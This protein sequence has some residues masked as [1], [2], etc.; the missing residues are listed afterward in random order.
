MS[1]TWI[2]CVLVAACGGSNGGANG[3]DDTPPDAPGTLSDDGPCDPN[4]MRCN[5]DVVEQ[6]AADGSH[7]VPQN[8]CATFCADGSCALDGLDVATDQSLDGIV[9]VKGAVMVHAGATL[10]TPMGDLTIFADSISVESGGAITSATTGSVMALNGTDSSSNTTVPGGRNASSPLTSDFDSNVSPGGSGGIVVPAQE[11]RAMGG[12]RI[13]LFAPTINMAGQ[14]LANGASGTASPTG[15]CYVPGSGGAGGGVLLVADD[16]TMSGL[17][18]TAGGAGGTPIPACTGTTSNGASGDLGRIKLLYGSKHDITGTTTS[19]RLTQGI[20]PPIPVTSTTHPSPDA[21]YNDGFLSLDINWAKSFPTTMGYYVL[22]DSTPIHPPT[23]ANGTFQSVDQVSFSAND[24]SNGDNYVHIVTIDSM[25][26]IG[27]IESNYHVKINT[28][29]PVMSS[30][31]HPSQTTFVNNTNP[32]FAW[33]YPQTDANVSAVYY[34]LDHFGDTVPALTSTALPATQKQLLQSGLDAGIWVLHVI[35]ADK[36]GRLTK[37]AGNYRVS[38]G[39]DPGIGNLTGTVTDA[40]SA[41][42]SGATV[43]LNHGLFDLGGGTV[44]TVT[45]NSAGSFTLSNI[46]AGT[47]EVEV[48]LATRSAAK[49]V[50]IAP[51]GGTGTVS[52]TLP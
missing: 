30:Q 33:S 46:P 20:A 52:V 21:I 4:A 28:L 44:G 18:S 24:V 36:Q 25:S 16:L 47:W 34:V 31:S 2:I 51:G 14:I 11:V 13:R 27:T 10:T 50:S 3:G 49:N 39:A 22:L 43:T 42:V 19:G 48:T 12:G 40:A 15:S 41:P 5:G 38:I 32:F 45:T 1:R 7:W 26:Q 23:A 29:P 6:C 17:I 35:A 9:H 37:V 8:T